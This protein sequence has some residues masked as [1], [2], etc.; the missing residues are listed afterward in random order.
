L[1][2]NLK[3][4]LSIKKRLSIHIDCQWLMVETVIPNIIQKFKESSI[5]NYQISK[6]HRNRRNIVCCGYVDLDVINA[7]DATVQG[8]QI[9]EA[10]TCCV[11]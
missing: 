9:T 10:Y 2:G 8:T 6:A 11:N 5:K 1:E 3:G 7:R 4:K